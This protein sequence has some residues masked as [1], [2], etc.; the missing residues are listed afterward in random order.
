MKKNV[1]TEKVALDTVWYIKE[2]S[3]TVL[4]D[5][6]SAIANKSM[7]VCTIIIH[8]IEKNRSPCKQL[9]ESF[10]GFSNERIFFPLF[11]A[12]KDNISCKKIPKI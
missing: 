7:Y 8:N 2:R 5:L 9:I 4:S 10:E 11:I 12:E 1:S 3:V 6:F